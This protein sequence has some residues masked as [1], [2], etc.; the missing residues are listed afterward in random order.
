MKTVT[1]NR[2][3]SLKWRAL[4]VIS[5][6]LII[7][8][9]TLASIFYL[10]TIKQLE[11][12]QQKIIT[13][14]ARELE[15]LLLNNIKTLQNLA[16]I[17]P[18][19]LSNTL[20]TGI[21]LKISHLQSLIKNYGDF[22]STTWGIDRLTFYSNIDKETI[23]WPD[24]IKLTDHSLLIKEVLSYEKPSNQ[25]LCNKLGCEQIIAVPVLDQQS[26]VH[27][28]L[29]ENSLVDVLQAFVNLT[30]ANISI[31]ALDNNTV[32][33]ISDK[34]HLS[35]DVPEIRSLLDS[36]D[37]QQIS[38]LYSNNS[39]R[40]F[41]HNEWYELQF[42]R[43]L[44]ISNNKQNT[45]AF[46]IT[47][48]VTE[49]INSLNKMAL[50]SL[51]IGSIGLFISESILLFLL[52][53][54]MSQLQRVTRYMPLLAKGHFIQFR[55]ELGLCYKKAW[56]LD[57]VDVIESSIIDASNQLELLQQEKK[58]QA[59]A[60]KGERDF[61][62]ELFDSA[63]IIIIILDANNNI[64]R[65]NKQIE[66]T[67][68]LDES[69]ILGKNFLRLFISKRLNRAVVGNL[70]NWL[71]SS[72]LNFQHEATMRTYNGKKIVINWT[73]S[74][75][76]TT[77][78][79][80]S[81]ILV[82]GL[83]LTERIKAEQNLSW[84]A[85]HDPLTELNNRRFFQASFE[86]IIKQHNRYKHTGAL[87]FFDLDQFKYVND[88]S[89]HHAGDTLLK[90]V[91]SQLTGIV[92]SSDILARLGGD[93]FA[94]ILPE[95]GME[96]A[97]SAAKKIL[98]ILDQTVLSIDQYNHKVSASIGIVLFPYH[99]LDYRALMA[100][101]DIA[102]YHAK[103]NGR[104]RWYVYS[105]D[106][107][108]IELLSNRAAWREKI[109]TAFK[110]NR[111][112]LHFQPILNIRE[113]TIKHYETLIRML[114]EKDELV[115]P[116]QFIPVAEQTGQI[117][118][119]DNWVILS[120]IEFMGKNK[121]LSLAIN[122]S[123]NAISDQDLVSHILSLLEQHKVEGNRL[124]IE[125]TE[126]AAVTN[127]T[128]ATSVMNE[129]KN[130]GCQ[131]ALDDFGTGFTSFNYLK[132]LPAS[133]VKIDGSFIKGLDHSKED[134]LFVR[135]LADVSHGLGKKTVAEFVENKEILDMLVSIGVDYAQGYYI[136]KPKAFINK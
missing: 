70:Q 3:V 104:G 23:S 110:D 108:T 78:K 26:Q 93:E 34:I 135:A 132:Q 85:H 84:L 24:N 50:I 134:Q 121:E 12:Q 127:V 105:P 21:N 16:E 75:I 100:N 98:T 126:T 62:T 39:L 106:D 128:K 53:G 64:L 124:I 71:Q 54:P 129:L 22:I 133:I 67:T 112:I 36:L 118:A 83:D 74:R 96:E 57:E 120:A 35:S 115:Y 56:A 86:K 97:I 109:D 31:L 45:I 76:T 58:Q 13:Q 114:D 6:V 55:K 29:L 27:V 20:S 77:E 51:L 44:P 88:V 102:M 122:L 73:Y 33:K 59:S 40:I 68:G 99:G 116:D 4:L 14:Q 125:I 79:N 89:G 136:G 107:Q 60:L 38:K 119:I 72:A 69:S 17:L 113:N 25:L 32:S 49:L 52:W 2:F 95:T 5:I 46:L 9:T 10:T 94:I 82:V 87:L 28:F 43:D 63:P 101:A 30:Q 15:S 7:V 11:I 80:K 92:R 18:L 47:N 123:G 90:L 61:I 66:N 81:A 1:H 91:A 41:Y 19:T 48:R 8:N 37:K 131:F 111:F 103:E 42:S 65:I 130:F 117:Q